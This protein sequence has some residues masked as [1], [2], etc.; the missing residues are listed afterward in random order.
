[1][2]E[3]GSISVVQMI[4]NQCREIANALDHIGYDYYDKLCIH[5]ACDKRKGGAP[6]GF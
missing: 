2:Q 1:M 5:A 4:R 3:S 6:D